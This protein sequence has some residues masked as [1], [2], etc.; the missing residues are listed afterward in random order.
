[1]SV[2]LLLR[3]PALN[4]YTQQQQNKKLKMSLNMKENKYGL[5]TTVDVIVTKY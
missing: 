5:L 3:I 2:I 4:I 1:M